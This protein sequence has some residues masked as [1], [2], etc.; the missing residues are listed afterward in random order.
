MDIVRGH[1]RPAYSKALGGCIVIALTRISGQPFVLNC[2]LIERVDSTPDTVVSMVDGKKYVVLEPSGEIVH[3]IR[4]YR[5]EIVALSN[6]ID[7]AALLTPP[8]PET[9]EAHL[10][11]VTTIAREV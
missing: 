6:H 10:S 5:S 2:D 8:A 3:A 9:H 7:A 4:L 1:G 11:S